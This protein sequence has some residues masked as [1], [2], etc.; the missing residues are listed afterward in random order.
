MRSPNLWW[1]DDHA[2]VVGT[3]IDGDDT[4]VASSYEVV[5][6]ILAHPDLNATRADADD[7]LPERT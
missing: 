4:L 1:P 7:Q 2:W 3:D 6:A 5:D